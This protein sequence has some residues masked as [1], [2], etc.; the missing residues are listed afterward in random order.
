MQKL[1]VSGAKDGS[2]LVVDV[3][4]GTV[5]STMEKVHYVASKVG[6]IQI[7]VL[8]SCRLA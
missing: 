1:L 7:A 2:M 3:Q 6:G 4:S 8:F 5:V